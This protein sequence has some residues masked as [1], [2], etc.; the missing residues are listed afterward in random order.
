MLRELKEWNEKL[1]DNDTESL[2]DII[3]QQE[4]LI[5]I[6]EKQLS[7]LRQLLHLHEQFMTLIADIVTFLTKYSSVVNEIGKSGNTIQNKI[8]QFDEVF[9]HIFIIYLTIINIENIFKVTVKIQE[10]E[11]T[12]LLATDKGE[13][14]AEEGSAFDRNNITQQ[15]QS[16]K[17]QLITLRKSVEKERQKLEATA[18]EHIKLAAD[19]EQVLDLLRENEALIKSR[20]LLEININSVLTDLKAHEVILLNILIY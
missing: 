1:G 17:Q 13:R 19:L 4:E 11:A 9:F 7:K 12:L 15:L 18:A 16:L 2:N 10:C 6:I 3:K 8:K 14:I 20:P 5:S